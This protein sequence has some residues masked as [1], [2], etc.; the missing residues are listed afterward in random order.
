MVGALEAVG[1][2]P[3]MVESEGEDPPSYAQ[4]LLTCPDP[5][6]PE[7][8]RGA[9]TRCSGR[10][11]GR[12]RPGSPGTAP[13]CSTVQYSTVKYIIYSTVTRYGSPVMRCT[14]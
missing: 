11:V 14:L 6:A 12:P 5:P 10:A 1:G 2:D 3:G 7:R 9:G 13:L 4:Q 8:R